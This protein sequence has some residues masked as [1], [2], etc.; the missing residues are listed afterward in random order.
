MRQMQSPAPATLALIL[1]IASMIAIYVPAFMHRSQ[2]T[3]L[4]SADLSSNKI[5]GYSAQALVRK[6]LEAKVAKWKSVML[7]D[8][9]QLQHIFSADPSQ[10]K[11]LGGGS[12]KISRQELQD[13]STTAPRTHDPHFINKNQGLKS[14][15]IQHRKL[16][17]WDVALQK[18][19]VLQCLSSARQYDPADQAAVERRCEGRTKRRAWNFLRAHESWSSNIG[20]AFPSSIVTGRR[21]TGVPVRSKNSRDLTQLRNNKLSTNYKVCHGTVKLVW[22]AKPDSIPA[23]GPEALLTPCKRV[24]RVKRM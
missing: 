10:F 22:T 20:G 2:I 3:G 11:N 24:S 16:E 19:M 23:P 14:L 18:Q 12:T 9:N 7:G 5:A 6:S 21:E 8:L 1:L 4:L 13:S 17:Q 15:E